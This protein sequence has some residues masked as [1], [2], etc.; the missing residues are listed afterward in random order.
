LGAWELAFRFT[1]IQANEP[2]ANFLNYYT[3]GF[4][5][6]F[7]HHTDEYTAGFNWYPN[8]WVKYVL[9]VGIDQLKDPS[10]IGAC[11]RTI[12]LS[13]SGCSS[14]SNRGPV[15][16][17]L[18]MNGNKFGRCQGWPQAGSEGKSQEGI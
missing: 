7:D 13:R 11:R 4:V 9:N 8:Y 18:R 5:P 14:G 10:T 17:E 6:T 2:G 15:E 3:P 12:T 16:C 1:G